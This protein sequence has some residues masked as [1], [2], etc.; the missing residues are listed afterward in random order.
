MAP[1]PKGT[2]P[3]SWRRDLMRVAMFGF[4]VLVTAI[5]ANFAVGGWH[6]EYLLER[7][8]APE[9]SQAAAAW[10][11]F[12]GAPIADAFIPGGLRG[13]GWD[14]VWEATPEKADRLLASGA[15]S[16]QFEPCR[17]EPAPHVLR[18]VTRDCRAATDRWRR[19]DG[20]DIVR[21]LVKG[22][23]SRGTDILYLYVVDAD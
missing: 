19:P 10:A 2:R 8:G 22:R 1:T 16:S 12:P 21:R 13:E 5:V 6:I 20:N 18:I 3:A 23:T 4:A 7:N 9:K 15:F 14:L 11:G 17:F